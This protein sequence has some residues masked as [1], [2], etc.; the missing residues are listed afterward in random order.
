M[1]F[2]RNFFNKR[3]KEVSKE[4]KGESIE[5]QSTKNLGNFDSNF[6]FSEEKGDENYGEVNFD[7]FKNKKE[8]K[9][10]NSEKLK[11]LESDLIKKIKEIKKEC[12]VKISKIPKP[13]KMPEKRRKKR[14]KGSNF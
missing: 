9:K 14:G 3:V 4:D 13:P 5:K 12:D 8:L 10:L 1:K 6:S 11:K 7:P 2:L